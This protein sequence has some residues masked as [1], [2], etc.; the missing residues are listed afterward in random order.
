MISK[1]SLMIWTN[2]AAHCRL[3]WAA[4]ELVLTYS[5]GRAVV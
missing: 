3:C 5:A 1:N 4:A 2:H